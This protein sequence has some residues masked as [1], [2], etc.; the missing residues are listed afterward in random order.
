M[1]KIAFIRL[2]RF[3]VRGDVAECN[4]Y[5]VSTWSFGKFFFLCLEQRR[6]LS[7][8]L[9]EFQIF[10]HKSNDYIFQYKNVN[11]FNFCTVLTSKLCSTYVRAL[12][13]FPL[14]I[15]RRLR[16]SRRIYVYK[17]TEQYPSPLVNV[18]IVTR[19]KSVK[20]TD[21]N[22]NIEFIQFQQFI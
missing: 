8:C 6:L 10:S 7:S 3:Y 5:L 15:F 19:F 22:K 14:R 16:S 12:V 4:F 20:K 9:S 1:Q 17:H 11:G 2:Q 21:N 13:F 18:V